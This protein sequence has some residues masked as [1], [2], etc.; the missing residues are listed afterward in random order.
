MRESLNMPIVYDSKKYVYYYNDE[1]IDLGFQ[2]W[3]TSEIVILL[4][5]F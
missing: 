5:S 3:M 1:L 2:Q 4:R